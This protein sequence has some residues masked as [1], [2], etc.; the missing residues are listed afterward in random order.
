MRPQFRRRFLFDEI[1]AGDQADDAEYVRRA[2]FEEERHLR[3]LRGARRIATGTAF[4]PRPQ[5][6][7]RGDV[8]RA[9]AGR[10]KESLV[11]GESEKID[12]HRLHVDRHDADA[13]GCIDEKSH[14]A[15]AADAAD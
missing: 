10:S 13:L 7:A 4:A 5:L 6:D 15:L 11:A 2:P 1:E 9:R 12:I 3:R 14:A 8:E